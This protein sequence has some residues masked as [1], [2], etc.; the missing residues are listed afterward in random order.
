MFVCVYLWQGV[1]QRVHTSLYKISKTHIC[2]SRLHKSSNREFDHNTHFDY[3]PSCVV[4]ACVA[5]TTL[6]GPSHF[7]H[8]FG[9]I[10]A[11]R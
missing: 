11:L 4:F 10:V 3:V 6:R 8:G 7:T 9:V 2:D 5:R 1:T